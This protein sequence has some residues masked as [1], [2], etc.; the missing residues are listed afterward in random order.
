MNTGYIKP[1]YSSKSAREKSGIT[2]SVVACRIIMMEATFTSKS[3]NSSYGCLLIFEVQNMQ[4]SK[5]YWVSHAPPWYRK[6]I[7]LMAR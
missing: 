5:S 6:A 2:L 4:L 1:A 3:G 7:V